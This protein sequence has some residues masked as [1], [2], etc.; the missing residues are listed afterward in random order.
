M[1][2]LH[3]VQY[4][5]IVIIPAV[6]LLSC[7]DDSPKLEDNMLN[8]E[9]EEVPVTDD[10]LIGVSYYGQND[11]S[12]YNYEEPQMGR[13]GEG[14]SVTDTDAMKQ[15][16]DWL[17][18]SG[19]N[20]LLFDYSPSYSD[21]GIVVADTATF[22]S[23]FIN[24]PNS[25]LLRFALKF[26]FGYLGITTNRRIHVNDDLFED[27]FNGFRK[28]ISFFE[29]ENYQKIDDKYLV[30]LCA[31][32]DLFS[33][34]TGSAPV[35]NELRSRMLAMG[36]NLYI[37]GEQPRWTPPAR[38]EIRL[39]NCV[40]AVT[41]VNMIETANYEA[42]LFFH[43]YVYLNW[44]YSKDYFNS[45]GVDFIPQIQP[46]YTDRV[47]NPSSVNF[48]FEGGE[49]FFRKYCNVAKAHCSGKRL[50]LVDSFNNWTYNNQIEPSV[51]NSALYLDIIKDEF[52]LK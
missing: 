26:N 43:Q 39:K 4:F 20:F 14:Y 16:I 9:I 21:S 24:R 32:S 3:K 44:E 13:Y 35:Y 49:D 2:T 38:Y 18:E 46:A 22:A 33:D 28:M 31:A 30:Y 25:G 50:I 51:N 5:I 45:W 29:N 17:A 1:K 11:W 42:Q 40:D 10:Y 34:S 36:Y 12:D 41:Y 15:H 8:F 23:V 19:I 37:I 47:V 48:V 6:I 27:F 52:K 7:E